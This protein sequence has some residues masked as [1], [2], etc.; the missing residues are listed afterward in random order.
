MHDRKLWYKN[1]AVA[2]NLRYC[3]RPE[4]VHIYT[5][6]NSGC[7]PTLM[8]AF[9]YSKPLNIEWFQTLHNNTMKL[10]NNGPI[11]TR[12]P[13]ENSHV[14]IYM[15]TAPFASKYHC[16]AG[17][18][19]GTIGLQRIMNCTNP[20]TLNVSGIVLTVCIGI[21]IALVLIILITFI[22]W[23]KCIK[24][25]ARQ[26]SYAPQYS[27]DLRLPQSLARRSY[28]PVPTSPSLQPIDNNK[29]QQ[30]QP[31]FSNLQ[32][33][34]QAPPFSSPQ[35]NNQVT[36]SNL[37]PTISSFQPH[38]SSLQP[39]ISN[40]LPL[41]VHNPKLEEE[42]TNYIS[43]NSFLDGEDINPYATYVF[44]T[45]KSEKLRETNFNVEPY[46]TPAPHC[47][48]ENLNI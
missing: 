22:I 45:S 15:P 28:L 40:Q 41:I 6:M 27:Y 33:S 29:L 2:S 31:I 12:Q 3:K 32:S 44:N 19:E 23:K 24:S 46:L 1:L 43:A 25:K 37:E 5:N 47:S 36:F 11:L 7:V 13:D 26:V 42:Q 18:I 9:R 38:I 8:C 39:A 14:S 10:I 16:K 4:I 35:A 21:I 17:K 48:Y 34:F 20:L 30:Q